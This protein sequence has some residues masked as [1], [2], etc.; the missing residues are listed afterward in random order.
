MIRAYALALGAGTQA[1]TQGFGV[2]LF[3]HSALVGD[4]SRAAGWIINLAVAE[5]VIRR[6]GTRRARPAMTSP[7]TPQQMPTA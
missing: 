3:G 2:A 4:L 5:W 7:V 1:F 6:T